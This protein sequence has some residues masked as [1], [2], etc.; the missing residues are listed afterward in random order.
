[1]A[2]FLLHL[3]AL[4]HLK[5]QLAVARGQFVQRIAQGDPVPGLAQRRMDTEELIRYLLH[6]D[7]LALQRRLAD[8]AIAQAV[9]Q[10]QVLAPLEPVAALQGQLLGGLVPH[11]EH[12]DRRIDARRDLRHQRLRVLALGLRGLQLDP[13]LAH[14]ELDPVGITRGP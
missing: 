4:L 1:M 13:D 5:L 10:A 8:E 6:A 14:P 2:H 7:A 9:A 3:L 12:A 11:E